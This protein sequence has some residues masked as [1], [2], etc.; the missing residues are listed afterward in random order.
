MGSHLL[1][2]LPDSLRSTRYPLEMGQVTLNGLKTAFKYKS[3][4]QV[5]AAVSALDATS[6]ACL[7]GSPL[8]NRMTS[9]SDAELAWA[10]FGRQTSCRE[11]SRHRA[12]EHSDALYIFVYVC[13]MCL[14]NGQ[15]ICFTVLR[16]GM[17]S[18]DCITRMTHR[19]SLT[20]RGDACGSWTFPR[21]S[22]TCCLDWWY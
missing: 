11:R 16:D 1:W 2:S 8:P 12:G 10:I 22:Q 21:Q 4:S 9:H 20:G 14:C 7:L 5:Y 15:T 19:R 13:D 18:P 3:A 17:G 6:V